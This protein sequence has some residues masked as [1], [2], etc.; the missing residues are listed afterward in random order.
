[1]PPVTK[2]PPPKSYEINEERLV[3]LPRLVPRKR[4]KRTRGKLPFLGASCRRHETMVAAKVFAPTMSDQDIA[5]EMPRNIAVFALPLPQSV[6]LL[7][8]LV[9]DP[10]LPYRVRQGAAM[11]LLPHLR[12]ERDRAAAR[13]DSG[14]TGPGP[15]PT[16]PHLRARGRL[17]DWMDM[18]TIDKSGKRESSALDIL[19]RVK[20]ED[21]CEKVRR[22]EKEIAELRTFKL[23]AVGRLR[24]ARRLLESLEEET[25]PRPIRSARPVTALAI[26]GA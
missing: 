14:P 20:P 6:R 8:A 11:I 21:P 25:V 26:S 24:E 17:R 23:R 10:D 22:L 18:S 7:T 16:G 5:A 19:D 12:A 15:S 9:H 13:T 2:L 4:F 3:N 1:V